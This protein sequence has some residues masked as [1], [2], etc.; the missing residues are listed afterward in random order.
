MFLEG[1]SKTVANVKALKNSL[2]AY[3]GPEMM[4]QLYPESKKPSAVSD[5]VLDE[6]ERNL[7][8]GVDVVLDQEGLT[9][10]EAL[11]ITQQIAAGGAEVPDGDDDDDDW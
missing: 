7:E 6:I 10:E 3:G 5:E 2:I 4:E 9:F 11:R 8:D 1:Q